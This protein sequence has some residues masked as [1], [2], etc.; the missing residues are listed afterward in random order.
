[1][2]KEP[3]QKCNACKKR[4]PASAYYKGNKHECRECIKNRFRAWALANPEKAA[5]KKRRFVIARRKREA[6]KKKAKS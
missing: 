5:A 1:M 4:R 6:A 3:L 2:E